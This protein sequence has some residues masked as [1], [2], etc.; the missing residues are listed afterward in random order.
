MARL[1]YSAIASLDGFVADEH[2][3]FDWAAPD[4]EV[5]GF[6]N[7]RERPIGTY[8]LGRRMYDVMRFWDTDDATTEQPEVMRDYAAIWRSADKIV[9][10]RSLAEVT[11]PR[12]RLAR[13]FD[14]EAVRA[15]KRDTPRDVSIGGPQLAAHAL[16]AGLVDELQLF[17]TP[18][19]VGRGNR[20]L[21]DDVRLRLVLIDEHRFSS[22]VVYLRYRLTLDE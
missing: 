18:V 19:V 9:Y 2:G 21:P 12:A 4:E 13:E 15:L 5:H 20:A 7:E 22:G 6:V 3:N 11:A 8:L 17:L 1:I 10:S 16:R 14:A